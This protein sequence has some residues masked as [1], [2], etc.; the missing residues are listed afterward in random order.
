MAII[1]SILLSF[2]VMLF[3]KVLKPD[4]L[5]SMVYSPIS[6]TC[7]KV[8]FGSLVNSYLSS[9]DNSSLIFISAPAMDPLF[10]SVTLPRSSNLGV[11][12]E[13]IC[14]VLELPPFPSETVS[15]T[16]YFPPAP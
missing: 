13:I 5:I 10:S 12:S 7:M 15:F 11:D 14:V 1:S 6:R 9:P 4:R 16:V 3:V 8:P 2:T